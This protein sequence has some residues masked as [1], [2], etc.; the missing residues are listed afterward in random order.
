MVAWLVGVSVLCCITLVG[1]VDVIIMVG[2]ARAPGEAAVHPLRG[3][4]YIHAGTSV[5]SLGIVGLRLPCIC[6]VSQAKCVGRERMKGEIPVALGPMAII[7]Y[8]MGAAGRR[9][10][11]S[12]ERRTFQLYVRTPMACLVDRGGVVRRSGMV[13]TLAGWKTFAA[14]AAAAMKYADPQPHARA[15]PSDRP[16]RDIESGREVTEVHVDRDQE[17][18]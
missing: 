17:T 2:D 18:V 5:R 4:G 9:P 7:W 8:D 3:Y 1:L 13:G 11:M 6:I 14:D 12:R 15:Q 10:W 16:E